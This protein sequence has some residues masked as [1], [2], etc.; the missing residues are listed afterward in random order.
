MQIANDIIELIGNTPLVG[1]SSGA[2]VWTALE[3]AMRPSSACYHAAPH[4][5]QT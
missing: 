3:V 2:A 5:C 1:I 4:A